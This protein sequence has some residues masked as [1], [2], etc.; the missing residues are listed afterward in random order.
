MSKAVRDTGARDRHRTEW[1]AAD[2]NV[3]AATEPHDSMVH[4]GDSSPRRD[5]SWELDGNT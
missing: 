2:S 5:L 1:E 3:R 4:A